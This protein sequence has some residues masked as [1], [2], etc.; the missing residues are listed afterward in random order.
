MFR[1]ILFALFV[2]GTLH[3]NAQD[4][5]S[6]KINLGI[7]QDILPYATGGHFACIWGGKNHVRVRA[8]TARV[9][10]PDFIIKEGFTNNDVTAYALTADYFLKQNWK[11][12]WFAGGLVYWKSSI[13]TDSKTGISYYENWLLN[14]SIGYN[15]TLYKHFYVSPWCGLNILVG[16]DRDVAVDDKVFTPPLLNPEASVKFGIYF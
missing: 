5:S 8:L 1:T 11:G 7:E 9:H 10:K 13:E 2:L 12:W 15:I 4:S 16:G 3:V 14:G 6:K